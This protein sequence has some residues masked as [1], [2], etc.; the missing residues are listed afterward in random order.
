M[1]GGRRQAPL[2]GGRSL[3][4]GVGRHVL[5][6]S[7]ATE[8]EQQPANDDSADTRPHRHVDGLLFLGRDLER[9]DLHNGRVLR[10]AKPAVSEAEDSSDDEDDCYDFDWIHGEPL[11]AG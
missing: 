3:D 2:A 6:L 8:D 5:S 9:T 11:P 4:G 10:V 1:G 7:L